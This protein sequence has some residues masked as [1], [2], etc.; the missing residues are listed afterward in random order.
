MLTYRT[1]CGT[2][3][4]NYQKYIIGLFMCQ[5]TIRNNQFKIIDTSL[6]YDK[7]ELSGQSTAKCTCQTLL[8]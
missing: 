7:I 8:N 1:F 5:E 4:S 6:K 2:T 3:P